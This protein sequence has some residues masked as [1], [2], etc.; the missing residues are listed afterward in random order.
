MGTGAAPQA[1]RRVTPVQGGALP[2]EKQIRYNEKIVLQKKTVGAKRGLHGLHVLCGKGKKMDTERKKRIEDRLKTARRELVL[3]RYDIEDSRANLRQDQV[4]L[5]ERAANQQL[6]LGLE[7]LDDEGERKI[8]AINHA[9]ERLQEG[10]YEL[11]ESCGEHISARRLDVLPWTSRCIACAEK[12][13][14]AAGAVAP[15][16]AEPEPPTAEERQPGAELQGLDDEQLAQGVT[17]AIVRDGTVPLDDLQ[18]SC[19]GGRLKLAG[20]LPDKR[21]LSRLQ[22]IVHDVLGFTEVEE[23]IRIDRMAWAREDRSPGS[24][25]GGLHQPDVVDGSG[26][27]TIDS[28]KEGKSMD[29]ADEIIPEKKG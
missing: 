25:E 6:A 3:Q 12:E 14:Q 22:Q 4:E 1:K 28:V 26:T 16:P 13:E 11:C 23:E 24:G 21:Q 8:A 10:E 29:P 15:P 17:D 5:E 19:E 9:L 18:V 20:V 2:E 7:Q 27:Q